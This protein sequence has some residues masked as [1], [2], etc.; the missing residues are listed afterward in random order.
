MKESKFFR[1][2]L[3]FTLM[4]FKGLSNPPSEIYYG[5]KGLWYVFI[6]LHK[7]I[8]VAEIGGVK[9]GLLDVLDNAGQKDT[10]ASSNIGVLLFKDGNYHY[11][12]EELKLNIKLKKCI[13]TDKMDYN[14]YKLFDIDAFTKISA[15][16]KQFKNTDYKINSD[17]IYDDYIYFRD[18]VK[19]AKDYQPSYILRFYTETENHMEK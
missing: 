1:L 4:G 13:Y 11:R 10:I 15:L 14:R 6:D 19:L 18:N 2:L 8:K 5:K 7:E 3:I 9:Y 12:N 17:E 16:K